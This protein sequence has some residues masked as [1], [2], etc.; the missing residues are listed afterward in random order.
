ME[1][2]KHT[3]LSSPVNYWKKANKSIEIK[4]HCLTTVGYAKLL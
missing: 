3:V 4:D 2:K 1:T